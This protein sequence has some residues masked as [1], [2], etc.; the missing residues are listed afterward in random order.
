MPALCFS[1][2]FPSHRRAAT[3]LLFGLLLAAAPAIRAEPPEWIQNGRPLPAPEFL[4]PT[5]DA[6]LPAYQPA[7]DRTLSGHLTGAASDV[8]P[9][10]VKSWIAA[11][12][13]YYPRVTISVPPPYAGSTGAKELIAGKLDFV[14]ISREQIPADVAV[15]KKKFGYDPSAVPVSGGTYRDRGFLDAIAVIVNQANPLEKITFAQLDALL[16]STHLRGY[17]KPVRTWGDLGLTGEWAD[18]PIRVWVVQ[19]WNGFEEFVRERVLSAGG[20]RGEW[21]PDLN[22]TKLIFPIPAHVAQDRYALGYAG[23][24]YLEPGDKM[25]ALAP[26]DRG[27]YYEPSYEEVA[28]ARYPLSRLVYLN[29]NR[30][31]GRPM[32]PVLAEFAR[33]ILSRE[34]QALILQQGIFIPLRAEQVTASRALLR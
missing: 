8:L 18:Q 31:P 7:A 24:A 12:E 23:I 17:A 15:F 34:G 27:P 26:E 11:F 21:R 5:L 3:A 10:L 32:N 14:F 25:L 6:A 19:P 22:F 28:R 4:Q 29:F 16:S 20:R 13:K 1:R 9:G 2:I 33:F 30:A